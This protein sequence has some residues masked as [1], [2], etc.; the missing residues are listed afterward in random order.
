MT[1]YHVQEYVCIRSPKEAPFHPI[2]APVIQSNIEKDK[3]VSIFT[4]WYWKDRHVSEDTRTH[5]CNTHRQFQGRL[6]KRSE[7]KPRQAKH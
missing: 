1:I 3:I 6:K 7:T 2:F 4:E 5:T